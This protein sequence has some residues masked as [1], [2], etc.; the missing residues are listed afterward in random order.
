M[1]TQ[2]LSTRTK[3]E[4]TNGEHLRPG[5][6]SVPEVDIYETADGLWLWA[7]MPGVDERSVEVNVANGVLSIAGHVSQRMVDRY[8]HIRLE[9]KRKAMESLSTKG[10][11]A[12]GNGTSN[13]TKTTRR[14]WEI[15]NVPIKMVG[16]CGFEPQ[17]PTVSR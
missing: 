4:V 15:Q 10:T 17:T 12:K 3:Q 11:Q 13:G 14:D 7:D 2:E 16:A 1:A 9:A 6:T 8:A 5:R